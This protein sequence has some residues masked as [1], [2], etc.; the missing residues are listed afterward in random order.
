LGSNA[1][2]RSIFWDTADV[3][4]DDTDSGFS[5][6]EASAPTA[7]AGQAA[8]WLVLAVVGLAVAC[9]TATDDTQIGPALGGGGSGDAG[10]A[11]GSGVAGNGVAGNGGAGSSVAGNGGFGA[12]CTE[13]S[14]EAFLRSTPAC[15]SLSEA[16]QRLRQSE[17]KEYFDYPCTGAEGARRVYLR[18]ADGVQST[19]CLFEAATGQ[20]VGARAS[21]DAPDFCER[22][23][24]SVIYVQDPRE[25][26]RYLSCPPRDP[27]VS[28]PYECV[29]REACDAGAAACDSGSP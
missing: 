26:T 12:S 22:S 1:S 24:Q 21:S 10:G 9:G 29:L 2:G 7:P 11:G 17:T 5:T 8:L 25:C 3:N 28:V 19:D 20:L 14:F 15:T 18:A 27:P 16:R 23:S 6:L 4:L 13:S